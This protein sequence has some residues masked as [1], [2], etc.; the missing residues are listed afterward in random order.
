MSLYLYVFNCNFNT[1]ISICSFCTQ[2]FVLGLSHKHMTHQADVY[3][4]GALKLLTNGKGLRVTLCF[5]TGFVRVLRWRRA[6][7]IMWDFKI[8]CNVKM[9]ERNEPYYTR[10]IGEDILEMVTYGK[11]I[12][13]CYIYLNKNMWSIWKREIFWELFDALFFKCKQRY[14]IAIIPSH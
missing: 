1:V 2:W 14:I 11:L 13:I 7:R 4:N 3:I 12:L 8:R 6:I 9:R 10:Q 5:Y